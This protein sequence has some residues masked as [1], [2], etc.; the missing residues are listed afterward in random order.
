MESLITPDVGDYFCLTEGQQLEFFGTKNDYNWSN[1]RVQILPC[2]GDN[3]YS[4]DEREQR[5]RQIA[6]G[7]VYSSQRFNEKE[8]DLD[9][10]V[11]Q[12]PTLIY[13]VTEL[14]VKPKI[15]I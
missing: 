9:N 6:Y 4:P 12:V 7:M 15:E 14:A 5:L 8:Y 3:C 1:M 2:V 11:E 10:L 13:P